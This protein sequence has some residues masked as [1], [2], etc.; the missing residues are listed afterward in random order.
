[1]ALEL[2]SG[3]SLSIEGGKALQSLAWEFT[4]IHCI[5]VG[6]PAK[7]HARSRGLEVKISS[8]AQPSSQ[9][10]KTTVTISYMCNVHIITGAVDG[11]PRRLKNS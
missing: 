1:M 4:P 7:S 2:V 5:S 9:V 8:H 6:W 11:F 3:V 10:M